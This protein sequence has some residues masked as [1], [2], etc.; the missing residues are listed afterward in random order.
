MKPCTKALTALLLLPLSNHK[1]LRARGVEESWL[2]LIE[3]GRSQSEADMN[4]NWNSARSDR[5]GGR[6]PNVPRKANATT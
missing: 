6:H 5:I 3:K 2:S 1:P 4:G